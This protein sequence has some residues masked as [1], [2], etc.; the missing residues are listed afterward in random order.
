MD[1]FLDKT[2]ISFRKGKTHRESMYFR[3]NPWFLTN[4]HQTRNTSSVIDEFM[5]SD[6]V[7]RIYQSRPD[8]ILSID[9]EQLTFMMMEEI[10]KYYKNSALDCPKRHYMNRFVKDFHQ[11]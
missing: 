11:W 1:M 3:S 2:F 4:K 10:K 9:N 6:V 8:L 5:A 7:K